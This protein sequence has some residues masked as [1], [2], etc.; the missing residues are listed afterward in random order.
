VGGRKGSGAT[1]PVK[2]NITASAFEERDRRGREQRLCDAGHLPRPPQRF[3]PVVSPV[4][5]MRLRPTE[6][7]PASPDASAVSVNWT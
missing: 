5:D 7:M 4:G 3:K 1:H 2:S 6:I